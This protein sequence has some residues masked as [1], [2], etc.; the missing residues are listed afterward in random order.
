MVHWPPRPRRRRARSR[1]PCWSATGRTTGFV[2]AEQIEAFKK[3]MESAGVDLPFKTY[4]GA[5]HSFT[6]PD[7]DKLA[8]DLDMPIGYNAEADK[9]S[10]AELERFLA[11]VFAE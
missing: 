4:A 3:E 1:R 9:A 11:K 5:R 6:N 8:E 7:A 2:P 10:W